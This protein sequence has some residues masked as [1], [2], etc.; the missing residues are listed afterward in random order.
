MLL[1][2]EEA[3]QAAA[4]ASA[5]G[6]AAG[7]GA[8][9]FVTPPLVAAGRYRVTAEYTETRA[10]LLQALTKAVSAHW[11]STPQLAVRFLCPAHRPPRLC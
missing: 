8:V 3:T 7:M 2:D 5:A 6:E 10:E 9:C 4:A 1:P 11:A